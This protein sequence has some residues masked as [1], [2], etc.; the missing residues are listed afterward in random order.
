MIPDHLN[1]N[2]PLPKPPLGCEPRWLVNERRM[3]DLVCALM[4]RGEWCHGAW[5]TGAGGG[6]TRLR[7][8]GFFK[9]DLRL[10]LKWTRELE[11]LAEK[12]LSRLENERDD[13][14]L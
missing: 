6:Y 13:S 3:Y 12:N 8:P 9:E 14:Y 2:I 7:D 11:K 4:R 1:E 5:C 10:I